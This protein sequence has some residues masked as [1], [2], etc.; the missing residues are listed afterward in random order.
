MVPTL[1]LALGGGG[2]RGFAHLGVLR[3]LEQAG[4]APGVV[5]GTSMGAI[6]AALYAT[7]PSLA[8]VDARLA[9]FFRRIAPAL[10]E[11]GRAAASSGGISLEAPSLMPADVFHGFFDDL[12]PETTFEHTRIPL[13][14]VAVDL[15]SGAELVYTSG[16]LRRAVLGSAA[17]PGIFPP[18]AHDGRILVDGGWTNRIPADAAR[19]LGA[20]RVVAV[21]VSEFGEQ[22]LGTVPATGLGIVLRAAEIT[23]NHLSR[24]RS[25]EADL[26]L[27]TPTGHIALHDAAR[28]AECIR[29][30][31]DTTRAHLAAIRELA[32]G[33]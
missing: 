33:S 14:I 22:A 20:T 17:L 3:E 4:L 30:G 16:P 32:S 31:A 11:L 23:R 5:A 27:T 25:R 18:I 9:D 1:G 2:V 21:E 15:L 7:L 13:A 6:V 29:A 10:H 24:R 12:I 26:L 8:D 19:A 28:L